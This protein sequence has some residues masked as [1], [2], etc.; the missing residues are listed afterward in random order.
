MASALR[1]IPVQPGEPPRGIVQIDGEYYFTETRPGQGI[2]AIGVDEGG[3]ASGENADE[4][5]NQVF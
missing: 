1:G 5:R 3:L 2:A 4:I